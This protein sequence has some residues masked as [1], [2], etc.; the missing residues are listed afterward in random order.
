MRINANNT[1]DLS[2][3]A[4]GSSSIRCF[5][6]DDGG[7]LEDLAVAV[8]TRGFQQSGAIGNP[9]VQ[10][11]ELILLARVARSTR[12]GFGIQKL[13]NGVDDSSFG[14]P[15]GR[16]VYGGCGSGGVGEGC[17]GPPPFG[18][19]SSTHAPL[20]LARSG[21]RLAV[22][23]VSAIQGVVGGDLDDPFLAVINPGTGAVAHLG[24]HSSGFGLGRFRSVVADGPQGFTAVGWTTDFSVSDP[25]ARLMI[26]A[27]L[28]PDAELVF[29][30]G[31]QPQP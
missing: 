23:G 29:Y 10:V 16:R 21:T 19:P 22:V 26:A 11:E 31:F 9:P 12:A 4:N 24:T 13:R 15:S 27:R 1:A 5:P 6:F 8:E 2:F 28:L 3:N 7:N 25:T 18:L 14:L 30:N 20:G 17:G